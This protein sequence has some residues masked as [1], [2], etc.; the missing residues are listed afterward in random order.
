MAYSHTLG[1]YCDYRN[2]GYSFEDNNWN[3]RLLGL[4]YNSLAISLPVH[5]MHYIRLA[6]IIDQR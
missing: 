2:G 5:S 4:M 1:D 6:Y 3:F